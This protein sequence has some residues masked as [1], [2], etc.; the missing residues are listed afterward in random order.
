[1]CTNV[2]VKMFLSLKARVLLVD[3]VFVVQENTW[4]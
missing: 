2:N 3:H 4:E 1:M